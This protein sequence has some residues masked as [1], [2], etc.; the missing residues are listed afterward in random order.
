MLA[1]WSKTAGHRLVTDWSQ[2]GHRLVTDWSHTGHTLVTHWSHLVTEWSQSGHRVVTAD[3]RGHKVVT[4][5]SQAM[6]EVTKWLHGGKSAQVST[7][8]K[9]P[10]SQVK[11]WRGRFERSSFD[12]SLWNTILQT[13]VDDEGTAVNQVAGIHAVDHAGVA[14]DPAFAECLELL[15]KAEPTKLSGPEQLAFW[16]SVCNA[17]C[18]DVVI[19][20]EKTIN[21]SIESINNLSKDIAKPV[22]DQVA[23]TVQ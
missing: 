1:F 9:R 8:F 18:I 5:W 20:H 21:V 14:A 19:D 23:G 3:K 15:D 11:N 16:M 17:L 7:L 10:H 13:H 4:D 22:W 2:I 12:P 6:K